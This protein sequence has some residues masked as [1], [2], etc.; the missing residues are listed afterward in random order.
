M[1]KKL[2]STYATRQIIH[3]LM[4]AKY[5]ICLMRHFHS[6]L[7]LLTLAKIVDNFGVSVDYLLGKE[8]NNTDL[9]KQEQFLLDSFSV[10]NEQGTEYSLQAIEMA[11]ATYK[12]IDTVSDTENIAG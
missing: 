10:L 11:K 1:P 8:S 6:G 7:T 12:R 9:S 2:L 3:Q 5:S 4:Y